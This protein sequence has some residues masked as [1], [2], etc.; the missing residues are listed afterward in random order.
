MPV[1]MK[2]FIIAMAVMCLVSCMC[3]TAFAAESAPPYAS[4]IVNGLEFQTL[5]NFNGQPPYF[6]VVPGVEYTITA[7]MNFALQYWDGKGWS[8]WPEYNSVQSP[9]TI[10]FDESIQYVAISSH[11]YTSNIATCTVIWPEPTVWSVI[12][13]SVSTFVSTVLSSV[14][15]PVLIFIT[16]NPLCLVPALLGLVVLGICIVRR[17]VYGA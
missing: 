14:G 10:V 17:F 4:T 11:G 2:I 3:M 5:G 8:Y 15:A 7:D 16:S 12:F 1:K 6:E 13:D 9:A